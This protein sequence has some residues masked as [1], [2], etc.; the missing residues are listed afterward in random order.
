MKSWRHNEWLARLHYKKALSLTV[1]W[2]FTELDC[3]WSSS[4]LPKSIQHQHVYSV[5]VLFLFWGLKSD[6]NRKKA[7]IYFL[8]ILLQLSEYIEQI[9]SRSGVKISIEIM[10]KLILKSGYYHVSNFNETVIIYFVLT[11]MIKGQ[12]AH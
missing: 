8:I 1:S 11:I 5:M 10:R 2:G 7:W 6:C 12:V 9:A 3:E 4:F